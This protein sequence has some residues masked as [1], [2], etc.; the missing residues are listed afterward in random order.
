MKPK[1]LQEIFIDSMEPAA[2]GAMKRQARYDCDT[3]ATIFGHTA[4]RTQSPISREP[5][6]DR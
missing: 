2:E 4:N 3:V 1:I 6:L 5:N